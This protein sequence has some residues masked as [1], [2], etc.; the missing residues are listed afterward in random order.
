MEQS[1]EYSISL[2]L[3]L[4]NNK[5]QKYKNKLQ[6]HKKHLLSIFYNHWQS[7]KAFQQSLESVINPR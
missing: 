1:S 6:K 7:D 2:I 5:S 4:F 3:V